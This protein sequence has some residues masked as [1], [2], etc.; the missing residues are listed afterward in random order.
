MF[1]LRIW[2]HN[3][4]IRHILVQALDFEK[5]RLGLDQAEAVAEY[6]S[7]D[8]FGLAHDHIVDVLEDQ[9]LVPMLQTSKLLLD[10]EKMMSHV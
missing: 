10:A 2:L 9:D 1:G 7:Y 3:R 6:I 8:E 5:D 4:A